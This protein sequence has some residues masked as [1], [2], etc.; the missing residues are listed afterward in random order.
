MHINNLRIRTKLLFLIAMMTAATA[1]VSTIGITELRGMSSALLADDAVSN[2]QIL[3][4]RANQNL[5]TLNRAEYRVA[6]D[7]S[8]DT[9]RA[10]ATVADN[11]REQFRDRIKQARAQATPDEIV[12]LDAIS[13]NYE[14]YVAASREVTK[15]ASIVAESIVLS[16]PQK[17]LNELLKSSRAIADDLQAKIKVYVDFLDGKAQAMSDAAVAGG[18]AAVSILIGVTAG[19][20]VLG[21]ALGYLLATSGISSPLNRSVDEL[22]KLAAGDLSI[23]ITGA[24]RGDECGDVAK[25]LE[26][27]KRAALHARELET[28]AAAQKGRAETERKQMATTLADRFEAAVGK[29]AEMLGSGATELQATAQSMS[30]TATQTNQQATN[31]AAAAEEANSGVQTVAA[32]A[33]QLTSSIR[34][35]SRQVAQS[36]Q[37]TGKAV[38]DAR[39]TDA[40]MKALTESAQKIGDVVQLISNIAGQTNLLA[41][42]ATIEAARAGDAGKGFAVVASEVK[43]LANQ[44]AK[45]TGEI[46]AQ[47][48]QVQSASAEA[49]QAIKGIATTI[50]QISAIATNIASAVEQ[51]GTATAEIA[52]NVQQTAESTKEVSSNIAGVSQA[53]NDTGAAA[54]QVLEAAGGVSQQAEQLTAE[55]SRFVASVRAA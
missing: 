32:A 51:Q 26:I 45:A 49:V 13:E 15:N 28:E 40:I 55:V 22:T 19:G 38:A 17:K 46:E 20:I 48:S 29:L 12:M 1:V 5:I 16:D 30:A 44:T 8:T 42:N 54:A 47:I 34:E 6:A 14:R 10:A 39:H 50:E 25:G 35:I 21:V 2:V 9:I 27:F 43:S 37:I 7:P 31:V 52:R 41:L 4:A 23:V 53:A 3:G 18:S 24:E 36:S 11:N 33:E